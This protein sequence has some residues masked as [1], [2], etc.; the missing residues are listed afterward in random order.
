MLRDPAMIERG[1]FLVP[2]DLARG[3][4]SGSDGIRLEDL[5]KGSGEAADPT[6]ASPPQEAQ[7]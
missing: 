7:P 1:G 5:G 3:A 6:Q 2:R 4:S